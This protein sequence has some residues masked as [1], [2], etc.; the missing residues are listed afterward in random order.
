MKVLL[1][2]NQAAM[3]Y[4]GASFDTI[5]SM[6]LGIIHQIQVVMGAVSPNSSLDGRQSEEQREAA[7]LQKALIDMV[8]CFVAHDLADVL[9]SEQNKG[10]VEGILQSILEATIVASAETQKSCLGT[11]KLMIERWGGTEVFDPIIKGRILPSAYRCLL[12]PSFDVSSGESRLVMHA[13]AGLQLASN[14]KLGGAVVAQI[15]TEALTRIGVQA[16]VTTA[17][18][19][20][21]ASLTTEP[22]VRSCL[23]NFM[24]QVKS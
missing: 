24:K 23:K 22:E 17:Y 1:L 20:H 3:R 15:L 8:Q 18:A 16:A 11:L 9:V 10:S 7:E 4:R 19:Q 21:V 13:V 14:A 6:F 12:A 5:N 2:V